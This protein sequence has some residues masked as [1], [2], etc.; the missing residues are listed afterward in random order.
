[1]NPT[2]NLTPI[3]ALSGLVVLAWG[4]WRARQQGQA[5]VL[6]WL[7]SV[8]LILPWL[9]FLG[10]FATNTYLNAAGFVLLLTVSSGIY[11]AV[12][13]VARRVAEEERAATT[14]FQQTLRS[15]NQEDW[16]APA[17]AVEREIT[18]ETTLD[19]IAIP[20][21]NDIDV[22]IDESSEID[23]ES[24]QQKSA[25]GSSQIDTDDL[26]A[27]RGIFG[28]DT[29]YVTD[30]VPYGKG[31]IFKGNLRQQD[32][33]KVVQQLQTALQ[34]E[35]GNR[36]C[37]YLVRDREEKPSVVVLPDSTVNQP[38][39]ATFK[40][41]A[42]TLLVATVGMVM[43]LA[44]N[45]FGFSLTVNPER[46]WETVPFATGVLGTLGLHEFGHRWMAGK[47]RV[48]LSPAFL[49]PTL[50][51]GTLG[52]L[53]RIESPVP[54]RK[55]LFDIAIA[56]PA[57]GG[58]SSLVLLAIGLLLTGQPSDLYVPGVLFQSSLLVGGLSR[59]I[60]GPRLQAEVVGIHPLVAVGWLGL[61]VTALSLLPAGQLDGGRM[62][63]AVYGRKIAGRTTFVS[64]AFLALA[65]L[66][67]QVALYWALLILLIARDTERPPQDEITETDSRRDV[68]ALVALFAMAVML[69]PVA[70]IVAE[71]FGIGLV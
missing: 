52:S 27:I 45:L 29:F 33:S 19:T 20:D 70:P 21:K 67:N 63:Q 68:L 54:H 50:G 26:K 56:G 3:I 9:V 8:S 36:Y 64:I 53:N 23:G 59:S 65:A 30:I 35:M 61:L 44:A 71:R 2:V 34:Q 22:G 28:I 32:A 14:K 25:T 60:L 11:I 42:A 38:T 5:G 46:W 55:A 47:Y 40:A 57:L 62:V 69:L 43:E 48:R 1:M 6:G 24:S 66:G 31:A 18:E 13:R 12:G 58:L 15:E 39:P 41:L 37:L 49:I 10:L 51:L 4:Y 7:Q 16:A 17:S